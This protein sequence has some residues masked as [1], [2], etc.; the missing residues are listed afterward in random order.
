MK[1]EDDHSPQSGVEIKNASSFT[2]NSVRVNGV[3]L[4]YR[5][6][7]FTLRQEQKRVD[8][9]RMDPVYL[10]ITLSCRRTF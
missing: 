8:K 1:H 7:D 2:S 6:K 10:V 4:S 9:C 3:V 5:D